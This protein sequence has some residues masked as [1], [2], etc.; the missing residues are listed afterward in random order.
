MVTMIGNFNVL[1]NKEIERYRQRSRVLFD[2]LAQRSK[3]GFTAAQFSL[4]RDNYFYRTYRTVPCIAKV[5]ESASKAADYI[6]LSS[7]ASN[8]FEESGSGQA[9]KSHP[10]LLLY[11][12]NQHAERVF[13]LPP[14]TLI[15]S[16][17]SSHILP[18]AR[19]FTNVQSSLYYSFN[20]IEVLGANYAQEEAATE[21]LTSFMS[22]FFEPYQ[23]YYNNGDFKNLIEYFICHIDGLEERHADDAR[24][25]LLQ[26]CKTEKDLEIAIN[27]INK[28]LSAQSN[29]WLGLLQALIELEDT[30]PIR[31]LNCQYEKTKTKTL[32]KE[33]C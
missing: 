28:I 16:L 7:A 27:S 10:E 29:L 9:Q 6:T 19:E 5:V 3:V 8:L 23:S 1:V 18:E 12:H 2:Y 4:Y 31:E 24:N 21:M 30:G 25:C 11:S 14:T 17:D 13:Q 20:H 15:A 22:A 26:W 33:F 32:Q